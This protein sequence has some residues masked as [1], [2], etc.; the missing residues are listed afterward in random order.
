MTARPPKMVSFAI[1]TSG[2]PGDFTGHV[3]F[4]AALS[5]GHPLPGKMEPSTPPQGRNIKG[6]TFMNDTVIIAQLHNP[7]IPSQPLLVRAL[8]LFPCFRWQPHTLSVRGLLF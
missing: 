3:L 5:P 6:F 7:V 4:S 2:V 8:V 1:D